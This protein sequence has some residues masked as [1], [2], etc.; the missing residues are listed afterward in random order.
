VVSGQISLHFVLVLLG[1][2][3]P[4]ALVAAFGLPQLLTALA[5]GFAAALIV[6]RY[7]PKSWQP[8][9]CASWFCIKPSQKAA[10]F[11]SGHCGEIG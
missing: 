8:F 6:H 11:L 9:V 3:L 5:G 7:P 1:I 10:Y 4:P 2:I